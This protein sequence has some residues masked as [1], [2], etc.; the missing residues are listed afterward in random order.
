M[1]LPICSVRDIVRV[2]AFR[3]LFCSGA[4]AKC[5]VELGLG[6]YMDEWFD[7]YHNRV[8]P[9]ELTVPPGYFEHC[10]AK[11]QGHVLTLVNAMQVVYDPSDTNAGEPGKANICKLIQITDVDALCKSGMLAIVEPFLKLNRMTFAK[12]VDRKLTIGDINVLRPFEHA[13]IRLAFSKSPC[14]Q[15]EQ[16]PFTNGVAGKLNMDK[17]LKLQKAWVLQVSKSNATFEGLPKQYN[18]D[19]NETGLE[20]WN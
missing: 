5:V 19:A 12:F 18:I 16:W 14:P 9:L 6:Q 15:G 1:Y 3:V 8:N 2:I 10:A 4:M 11:L 17:L 7:F 20:G 13:A